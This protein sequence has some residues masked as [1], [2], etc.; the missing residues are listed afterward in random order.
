MY[1]RIGG[2]FSSRVHNNNITCVT[3]SFS[4]TTFFFF[5]FQQSII[6]NSIKSISGY[7][8]ILLPEIFL[9]LEHD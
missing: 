6:Y 1:L 5:F 8:K 3:T 4:V 7:G 9:K 2:A